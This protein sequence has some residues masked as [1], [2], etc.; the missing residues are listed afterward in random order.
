MKKIV[1]ILLFCFSQFSYAS[2][3]V[4]SSSFLLNKTSIFLL[5]TFPNVTFKNLNIYGCTGVEN[6]KGEFGSCYYSFDSESAATDNT[7]IYVFGQDGRENYLWMGHANL[8]E[9][10]PN[11]IYK[12]LNH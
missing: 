10:L 8:N 7:Y 9:V 5:K 11:V 6:E 4:L 3:S 1:L 12:N 2:Q